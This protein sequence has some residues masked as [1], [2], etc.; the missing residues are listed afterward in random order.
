MEDF[1]NKLIEIAKN[2][3]LHKRSRSLSD[4]E[5]EKAKRLR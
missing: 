5:Y 1:N 3:P 4:E 2:S